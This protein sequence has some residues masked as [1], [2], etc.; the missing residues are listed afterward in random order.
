[1]QQKTKKII[2]IA[3][4]VFLI[5]ASCF[6]L[7][8]PVSVFTDK[9]NYRV[10]EKLVVNMKNNLSKKTCFSSCFP[11]FMEARQGE[12]WKRIDYFPCSENDLA[13]NCLSSYTKKSF[14]SQIS[15]FLPKGSYRLAIPTCYRC[16]E[17]KSF[18]VEKWLYSNQ[19]SVN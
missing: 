10:G 1:M 18:R 5:I 4:A 16:S 15:E 8:R 6:Y 14:E 12:G 7:W 3:I 9:I 13:K 17:N 11:F 19:F 2:F